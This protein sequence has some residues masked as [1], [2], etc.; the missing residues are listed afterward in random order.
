MK[1][2]FTVLLYMLNKCSLSFHLNFLSI[3]FILD[4]SLNFMI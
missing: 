2:V 1:E 3:L 4:S